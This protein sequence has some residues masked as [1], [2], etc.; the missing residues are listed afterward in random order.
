[1]YIYDD[2]PKSKE[3]GSFGNWIVWKMTG[4][5]PATDNNYNQNQ[6][7]LAFGWYGR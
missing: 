2:H 6:E 5:Q 1:M 7:V 4:D 3:G